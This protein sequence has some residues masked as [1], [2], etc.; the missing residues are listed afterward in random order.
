MCRCRIRS[1]NRATNMIDNVTTALQVNA[2]SGDGF[3]LSLPEARLVTFRVTG[4]GSISGGAVTIECCPSS[5]AAA[6]PLL[7]ASQLTWTALTT[8]AVPANATTEYS[9][10]SVSGNFRARI[11]TTISGGTVAVTAVR[12]E[13][14]RGSSLPRPL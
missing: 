5:A 12:P 6:P 11:S 2:T 13:E 7:P 3:N 8:I 1:E 4:N 9:A 14:Q 10:G